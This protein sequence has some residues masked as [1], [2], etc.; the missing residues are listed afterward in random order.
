VRHRVNIVVAVLSMAAGAWQGTPAQTEQP[1]LLAEQGPRAKSS[2]PVTLRGCLQKGQ[3]AGTFLLVTPDPLTE[4]GVDPALPPAAGPQDR[5][6]SDASSAVPATAR[7]VAYELV[8]GTS[9]VDLASLVGKRVEVQGAPERTARGA[10]ADDSPAAEAAA[11]DTP[12]A[13]TPTGVTPRGTSGTT[14]AATAGTP[15]QRS[16]VRLTTIRPVGGTCK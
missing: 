6:A 14:S 7:T 15:S 3:A 11:A 5:V 1:G 8:A 10:T 13:D 2:S 16:R 9:D 12:S 4:S